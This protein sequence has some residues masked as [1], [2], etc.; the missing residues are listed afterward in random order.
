MILDPFV[1]SSE[2]AV[3]HK[4][5][6]RILP[7][8]MG[9][10]DYTINGNQVSGKLHEGSVDIVIGEQ[11]ERKIALMRVPYCHITFTYR[12]LSEESITDFRN[13]FELYFRRG[14]G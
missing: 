9:E 6:F 2:M 7:R 14:G 11:Q 1:Y 4:D 10:T 5:F 13:R 3:T 8:A 12:N